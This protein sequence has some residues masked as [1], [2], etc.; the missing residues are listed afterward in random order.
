MGSDF[1]VHAIALSL[2][3]EWKRNQLEKKNSKRAFNSSPRHWSPP[4]PD[5][6]KINIDAAI[7]EATGSVGIS[8][9]IRYAAGEFVRAR[10]QKIEVNMQPREAEAV[11]L[12]EALS[13]TKELG[14][15]KCIFETDAKMLA[16][17]CK[18]VPGRS[19]FHTIVLDCVDFFKHFDEVLVE[20]VHRSANGVAHTL[21][22]AAHSMSGFQ[23]WI[24]FASEIISDVLTIDSI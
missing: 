16:D 7:F 5:W 1:G 24:D 9:I 15:Q 2:L 3:Q 6:I 22:R 18:G 10:A 11:S 21:A 13:W 14:F 8:S 20:F 23:E 19:F 4:P 17:A 12:K